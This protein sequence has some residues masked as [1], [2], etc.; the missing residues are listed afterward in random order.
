MYIP[1]LGQA[2]GAQGGPGGPQPGTQV[3]P[4]RPEEIFRYAIL[5]K[6][7]FPLHITKML[8]EYTTYLMSIYVLKINFS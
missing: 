4:L 1:N 8:R 2:G 6:T 5:F 7:L 3:R